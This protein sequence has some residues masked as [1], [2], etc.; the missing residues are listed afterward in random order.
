VPTKAESPVDAADA[1]VLVR[2]AIRAVG[3][4]YNYRT[5]SPKVEAEGVGNGDHVRLRVWPYGESDVRL[6]AEARTRR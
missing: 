4:G 3:H 5:F 1:S 2:G 6:F